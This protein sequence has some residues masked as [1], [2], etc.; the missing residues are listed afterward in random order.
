MRKL[1]LLLALLLMSALAIAEATEWND[2]GA[3]IKAGHALEIRVRGSDSYPDI[4]GE[5][6]ARAKN[7][8]VVTIK[9][10]YRDLPRK[11]YD[12]V[13]DTIV[14]TNVNVIFGSFKPGIYL[15]PQYIVTDGTYNTTVGGLPVNVTWAVW[16]DN[17]F[18]AVDPYLIHDPAIQLEELGG[19]WMDASSFHWLA[20]AVTQDNGTQIVVIDQ[21]LGIRPQ[22]LGEE[23]KRCMT[24]FNM[25]LGHLEL[26]YLTEP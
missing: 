11:L 2:G 16:G 14:D 13:G 15:K 22:A 21:S 7:C 3:F 5:N 23:I 24:L 26:H 6:L 4:Y 17:S 9:S 10:Q 19:S 20:Y 1:I 18:H 8:Q 12:I 25:T